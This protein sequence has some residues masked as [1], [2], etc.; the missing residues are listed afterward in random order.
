MDGYALLSK[1][2]AEGTELSLRSQR[3]VAIALGQAK[4]I[5]YFCANVLPQIS[6]KKNLGK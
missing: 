6:K 1:A 4:E 3:S 2:P 5:N